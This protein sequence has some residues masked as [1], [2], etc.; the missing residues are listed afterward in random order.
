MHKRGCGGQETSRPAP[1]RKI[2]ELAK[3]CYI[4]VVAQR[5]RLHSTEH[6]GSSKQT[7]STSSCCTRKGRDCLAASCRDHSSGDCIFSAAKGSHLVLRKPQ[8]LMSCTATADAAI[9]WSGN[10]P[11]S[12]HGVQPEPRSSVSFMQINT[13]AVCRNRYIYQIDAFMSLCVS[14]RLAS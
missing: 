6:S 5:L 13:S 14:A 8:E 9:G 3:S 1:S 11:G 7:C 10:T 4:I 12:Y 2:K